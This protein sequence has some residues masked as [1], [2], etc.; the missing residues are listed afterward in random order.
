MFEAGRPD[1]TDDGRPRKQGSCPER[2]NCTVLLTQE[3]DKICQQEVPEFE[4]AWNSNPSRL[5]CWITSARGA[6]TTTRDEISS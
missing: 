3:G 1:R 5:N 6:A 2:I 4:F